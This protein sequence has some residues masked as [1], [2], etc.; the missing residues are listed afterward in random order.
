MFSLWLLL[1]LVVALYCLINFVQHVQDFAD[2]VEQRVD[3]L[4]SQR[5]HL[6]KIYFV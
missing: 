3:F 5:K 1:G 2:F 6:L 4:E